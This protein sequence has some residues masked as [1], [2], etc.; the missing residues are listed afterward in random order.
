M[1]KELEGVCIAYADSKE[2]GLEPRW[3]ELRLYKTKEG[4]F[5]C[6]RKEISTV[7][8]ESTRESSKHASNEKEVIEFFGHGW[9]SKALYAE[10][11]IEDVEVIE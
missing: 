3:L 1:S 5:L 4:K 8:G 6:E 7:Q 10:A 2:T 9:V 11:G